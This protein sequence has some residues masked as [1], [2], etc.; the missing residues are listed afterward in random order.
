MT[1]MYMLA[2]YVR[3]SQSLSYNPLKCHFADNR[4]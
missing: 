3:G 2:K 1:V 4:P